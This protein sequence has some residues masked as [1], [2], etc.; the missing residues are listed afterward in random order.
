MAGIV[1]MAGERA[2]PETVH[3]MCRIL[4]HRGRDETKVISG[5]H[6]AVACCLSRGV[7]RLDQPFTAAGKK[8]FVDGVVFPRSC[9][10]GD[11]GQTDEWIADRLARCRAPEDF[12]EFLQLLDGAFAIAIV[13][14]DL[15]SLYLGRDLIGYKPLHYAFLGGTLVFASEAKAL[16][17]AGVERRIDPTAV[18]EYLLEGVVYAP[19]TPFAGIQMLVGGGLLAYRGGEVQI[20]RAEPLRIEPR[21]VEPAQAAAR[22]GEMTVNALGRHKQSL[23]GKAIMGVGGVDSYY[24]EAMAGRVWGDKGATPQSFTVRFVPEGPDTIKREGDRILVTIGPESLPDHIPES[25]WHS[26][27]LSIEP[28]PSKMLAYGIVARET[29]AKYLFMADPLDVLFGAFSPWSLYLEQKA[30]EAASSP[31][32]LLGFLLAMRRKPWRVLGPRTFVKSVAKGILPPEF[33]SALL[34]LTSDK[35]FLGAP[36][37]IFSAEW[38][39]RMAERK[40][41]LGDR[42]DN[43]RDG[44]LVRTRHGPYYEWVDWILRDHGPAFYGEAGKTVYGAGLCYLCPS[45]DLPLYQ[46]A[47]TI[48]Y[49]L[50]LQPYWDKYIMRKAAEKVLPGELVWIRKWGFMFPWKTWFP[51]PLARFIRETLLSKRALSRGYNDPERLR[52]YVEH[53]FS[54]PRTLLSLWPLVT[55]ELFHQVFI[56]SDPRVPPRPRSEQTGGV[57]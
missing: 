48:P 39:R 38:M 13:A 2:E 32:G 6:L 25:V 41:E 7:D 19:R 45:V 1:G 21:T 52:Q 14:E 10:P 8:L 31:A 17:A 16:F 18:A 26:E 20:L 40:V 43:A 35:I 28:Y 34:S 9:R 23:K 46:F 54:N 22:I 15:G 57:S 55:L 29:G 50:K 4:A 42:R 37:R 3:E 30:W 11:V 51:G 24:M 33:S 53:C 56:D 49:E 27:S 36:L 12:V 47:M 5:T 44:F